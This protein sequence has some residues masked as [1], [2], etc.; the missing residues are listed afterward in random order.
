ML[1]DAVL[2]PAG[3]PAGSR[4]RA[5]GA[6]HRSG[7]CLLSGR[8]AGVRWWP[9]GAAAAA[10]RGG[11]D[12]LGRQPGLPRRLW[13][14]AGGARSVV[15]LRRLPRR[16][17]RGRTVRLERRAAVPAGDLPAVL[18]AGR[19]RPA[20]LGATAPQ[21]AHAGR[22]GRDQC[23]C[24]RPAAGGA[25]PAG[26]DQR[27]R[28]GRG[29][30]PGADRTGRTDV[31]EAAAVAGGGRQRPGGLGTEPRC[32]HRLREEGRLPQ[33]LFPL[34]FR[35]LR[36][37]TGPDPATGVPLPMIEAA[38]QPD[39]QGSAWLIEFILCLT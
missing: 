33:H 19:R 1:A 35:T 16:L 6:G 10:G 17:A 15:H 32:I 2:R 21:P 38:L 7:G 23:R 34:S 27:H 5:A 31:L 20:V 14:G 4:R 12:R 8:R 13:C 24:G 18:P 36:T 26:L 9:R 28:W 3:R 37:F 39:G 22:T 29:F 25:L 11:A 30:R